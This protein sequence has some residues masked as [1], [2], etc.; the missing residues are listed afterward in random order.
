MTMKCIYE[1]M[2][3]LVIMLQCLLAPTPCQSLSE[4]KFKSIACILKSHSSA[5]ALWNMSPGPN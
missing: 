3:M 1:F 2:T 4:V 5:R